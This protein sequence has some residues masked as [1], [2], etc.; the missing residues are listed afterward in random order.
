MKKRSQK[1]VF[2]K[3]FWR[4]LTALKNMKKQAAS[5]RRFWAR[6]AECAGLV[7]IIGAAKYRPK[8]ERQ[9]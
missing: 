3:A 7:G 4:F 5:E 8:I 2:F 6:L 1:E 9:R